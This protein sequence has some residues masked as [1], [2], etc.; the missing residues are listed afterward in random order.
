MVTVNFVKVF[1]HTKQITPYWLLSTCIYIIREQN[2]FITI[3]SISNVF[4]PIP[5]PITYENQYRSL[6]VS[7]C[8]SLVQRWFVR[9]RT[10]GSPKS[11]TLWWYCPWNVSAPEGLSVSF[12]AGYITVGSCQ[13]NCSNESNFSCANRTETAL[14]RRSIHTR[15]CWEWVPRDLRARCRAS[16]AGSARDD[17]FLT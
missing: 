1:S 4:I 10:V 17:S 15:D 8:Q 12:N 7:F 11:I 5:S 6:L 3:F 2:H 9:Q 14:D 16:A 13:P